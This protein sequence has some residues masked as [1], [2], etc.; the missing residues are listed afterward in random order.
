MVSQ[1][2]DNFYT[3]GL[4][5]VQMASKVF[6]DI[7]SIKSGQAKIS[8]IVFNKNGDVFFKNF[9]SQA[10]VNRIAEYRVF[11]SD[12]DSYC[13]ISL[14]RQGISSE[15]VSYLNLPKY[16]MTLML[17]ENEEEFLSSVK[18]AANLVLMAG[19]VFLILS[20]IMVYF[21]SKSL[22]K[23]IIQLIKSLKDINM[24]TLSMD[25]NLENT[26]NEVIL[27]GNAFGKMMIE[28]RKTTN[29]LIQTRT[30]EINANYQALQ[31]QVNPHFLCN[32]LTVIG[33]MGQQ[34][35]ET[36][37]MDMCSALTKMLN[38]ST[39]MKNSNCTIEQEL[40]HVTNYLK[41][42][43]YRYLDFL[44]Y[45][46]EVDDILMRIEIPRLILQPIVENS[47]HHGFS[48][49]EPPYRIQ[50][51]GYIEGDKW[52]IEIIDNGYGVTEDKLE[53]LEKELMKV[54]ADVDNNR[55]IPDLQVGGLGL[56]NTYARLNIYYRGSEIFYVRNNEGGGTT[57]II[58]GLLDI[59][60]E[61]VNAKDYAG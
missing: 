54:R 13:R 42:M 17:I 40:Q 53:K 20:L 23:P 36:G 51:K 24:D 5:E 25:L 11:A 56:I 30:R 35:G 16:G 59:Y 48:S 2:K 3:Y 8:T 58:A 46:I 55:F 9:K 26:N 1:I 33:T 6:E 38:Y 28:V 12:S 50:I 49:I 34:T 7:L 4:V 14:L 57:V 10:I 60:R 27:L 47:F 32:V 39:S 18:Y 15:I 41:L 21:I 22:T 29:E 52:I 43:K 37:I 44:E 45:T 61:D 31:S 19:V